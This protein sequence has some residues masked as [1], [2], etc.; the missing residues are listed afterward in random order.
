VLAI[1]FIGLLAV[2]V[3]YARIVHARMAVGLSCEADGPAAN[4]NST[5]D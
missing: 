1:I 2:S 3:H 4:A 5:G